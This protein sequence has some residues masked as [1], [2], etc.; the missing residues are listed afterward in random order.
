MQNPKDFTT[1]YTDIT[2]WGAHRA[3]PERSRMGRRRPGF[4]A[5]AETTFLSAQAK[6]S[7]QKIT[8]K[9]KFLVCPNL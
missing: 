6:I 4:G 1:D 2:D 8:K 3:C 7:K 9:T 5:A